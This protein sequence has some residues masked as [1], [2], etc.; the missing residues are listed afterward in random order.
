MR[1]LLRR[2]LREPHVQPR[3]SPGCTPGSHQH[4]ASGHG[5]RAACCELRCARCA[6][7]TCAAEALRTPLSASAPAFMRLA[8]ASASASG[9]LRICGAAACCYGTAA[10]HFVSTGQ[11][12]AERHCDG[13]EAP[14][15]SDREGGGNPTA[16]LLLCW[17]KTS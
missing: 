12:C 9:G 5:V 11:E 15:N 1:L 3:A 16:V 4:R 7:A 13:A 14:T 10:T 2:L 6:A 8:C 17:L